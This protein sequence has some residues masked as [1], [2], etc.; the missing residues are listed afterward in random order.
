M[1]LKSKN[2]A[3]LGVLLALNQIFIIASSII[4]TNTIL[5]F[6]A[7]ALIIGIVIIEFGLRSGV[8]F[9][10]ASCILGYIL[11]FNKV[12]IITYIGFFGLY[13][14]L[15]YLI[16]KF[17]VNKKASVIF[18]IIT[19]VIIFDILIVIIYLI[20]RLFININLAWW[21]VLIGQVAFVLYDYAFT[22]FIN[23]YINRIKPKLKFK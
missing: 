21:L 10:L 18:E 20:T 13:S 15:K 19:K 16:E 8:A 17:F 22:V 7:A 11:T 4:E 12:E 9:Y 14:I 1:L 2:V 6:F 3:Y 23:S 5:F